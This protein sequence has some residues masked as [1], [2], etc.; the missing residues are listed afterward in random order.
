VASSSAG[1][2]GATLEADTLVLVSGG[3]VPGS[4]DLGLARA[5]DQ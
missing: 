2:P 4:R 5:N 3:L 1:R